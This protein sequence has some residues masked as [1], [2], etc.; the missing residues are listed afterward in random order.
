MGE[1]ATADRIE[2]TLLGRQIDDALLST[3]ISNGGSTTRTEIT[4]TF[5][6]NQQGPS[7]VI[8]QRNTKKR[9]TAV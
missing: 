1:K 9:V 2:S 4:Q 7:G 6:D 3:W 8:S 5:Y